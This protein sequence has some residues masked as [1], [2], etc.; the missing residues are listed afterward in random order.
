MIMEILFQIVLGLIFLLLALLCFTL[1]GRLILK[2][3]LQDLNDIEKFTLYSV[4]GLVVFTLSAYVLAALHL[5]SLMWV[6]PALGLGTFI[7]YKKEILNFEL[8]IIHKFFF[9]LTFIVGIAGMVA[10][11][12]LSGFPYRDGIYFWS[13][14]G[15]DGIWH[16][17][18]MESMKNP[19]FPFQNPEL[20]GAKLQ[21]YHFFADLLMSEFSRLFSFSPLDIYFRFMPVVFAILLGLTS[22]IFV[23]AWRK[24]EVAGI[25]AMFFTYFAGSFG[26]LLYVPTHRSLGGESIFWVSQTQSVLGNPPHAAAFIIIT[27]FL[28]CLFKYLTL[29]KF[30]YFVICAIL[31]SSLVEYKIYAGVL[32]LGGLLSIGILEFL[33]KR[34]YQALLL[35]AATFAIAAVIYI[36][37]SQNSQDFLIWQPWWFIRTMVVAPD[38]LNW[39]DLELRRQTYVADGNLK[40]VIQVEA[41]AFLIFLFGNLGMRFLGFWSYFK[42]VKDYTNSFNIFFLLI[43]TVSFLIP[44]FFLQKGVAWNTIQ[45]NQYF[46]LL[47]G[48]LAAVSTVELLS[49]IRRKSFKMI[50]LAVIIIL[51]VPTQAGLLW[52]FYSNTPLSKVSNNEIDA[53]KFLKKESSKDAIILTAPFNKYERDNY[54][55]PPIPI[56]AWY[57]TGYVS[58]FSDRKTLISD[59]EQ[60]NIMGYKMDKLMLD[61]GEAFGSEDHRKINDFLKKYKVDYIYLVWNQKIATDSGY[62]NVDLIFENKDAKVFKVKK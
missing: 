6:F 21:N 30:P 46:L 26:Y 40:R 57:D 38:R 23:R 19:I 24:S 17:A 2:K 13:S 32:V 27:A 16:L 5:R 12:A 28:F 42:K 56:Y 9:L 43:T 58:A 22:F 18:L 14:H 34:T 10:V 61:R 51:A 35:F 48:Y 47:F 15:H 53:L 55:N 49:F 37:N 52:Q 62:L 8:K 36:P 59:E 4:F 41:T 60:V 20:Y 7:K 54:T 33:T 45:F 31:G 3:N 11:N 29:R 1:P 39:L 25:W 44:V 50:V